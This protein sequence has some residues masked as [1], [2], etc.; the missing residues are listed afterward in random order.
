MH[1][2]AASFGLGGLSWNLMKLHAIA[3]KLHAISATFWNSSQEN[4]YS[5][6]LPPFFKPLKMAS[7]WKETYKEDETSDGYEIMLLLQS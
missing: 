5:F 2:L 1:L 3:A 7:E 6:Y 4:I